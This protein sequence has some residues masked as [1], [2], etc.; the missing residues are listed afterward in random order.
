MFAA[1]AKQYDNMV[2]WRTT[3]VAML[4]RTLVAKCGRKGSLMAGR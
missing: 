1:M 3:Q 4:Q 2:L